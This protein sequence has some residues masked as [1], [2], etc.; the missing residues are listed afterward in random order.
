MHNALSV[1]SLFTIA[2]DDDVNLRTSNLPPTHLVGRDGVSNMIETV[3]QLLDKHGCLHMPVDEIAND[4]N[5][6]DAGLTPFAAIR[7]M[8][9][10]EEAFDIEFPVVMLRRR[11]FETIDNIVACLRE[12]KPQVVQKREAA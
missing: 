10:M 3:R 2:V 11:S 9:A 1:S 8:L 12:L 6:Y 7:V 4:A 5:L